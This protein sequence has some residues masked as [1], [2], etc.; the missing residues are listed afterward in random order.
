MI[1]PG[2]VDGSMKSLLSQNCQQ[3]E[4]W[5]AWAACGIRAEPRKKCSV[6][7]RFLDFLLGYAYW[8]T[9][10]LKP[11]LRLMK[12]GIDEMQ[13]QLGN[14]RVMQMQQGRPKRDGLAGERTKFEAKARSAVAWTASL[15]RRARFPCDG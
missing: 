13:Q 7:V 6:P 3:C 14:R 8:R 15:R 5:S 2:L 11:A 9:V 10:D 1:A 12:S 4:A